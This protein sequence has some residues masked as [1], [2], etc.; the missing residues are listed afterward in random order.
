MALCVTA[1]NDASVHI[2]VS[3]NDGGQW[4]DASAYLHPLV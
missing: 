2:M 4:P 1:G 3:A